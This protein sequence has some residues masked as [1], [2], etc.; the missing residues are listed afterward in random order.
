MTARPSKSIRAHLLAIVV[1]GAI[2]PL[3]LIGA[4]LTSRQ[5]RSGRDLLGT[6][7]DTSLANIVHT[8]AT[9]WES[10]RGFLILL[11]ANE[12]A[13]EAVARGTFLADDSTYFSRGAD[14]LAAMSPTLWYVDRGGREI[15][16]WG[17]PARATRNGSATDSIRRI[18]HGTFHFTLPH[19]RDGDSALGTLEAEV[20]VDAILP[21]DSA[22]V[23][24]PGSS[25][26][27]RDRRAQHRN[28]A[29][30]SAAPFPSRRSRQIGAVIVA[31]RDHD[32]LE[33][34]TA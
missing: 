21:S 4:W 8:I 5:V 27:V 3:A 30:G 11:A 20:L 13:R 16:R 6:Q 2:L 18:G 15:Y 28:G 12:V 32:R 29:S 7:L 34:S 17:W 10:R 23:L 22:R 26:A 19:N 24:L 14:E 9:K 25:F 33:G 31:V 1:F